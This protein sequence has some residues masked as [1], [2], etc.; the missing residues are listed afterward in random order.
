MASSQAAKEEKKRIEHKLE[1]LEKCLDKG[2][3]ETEIQIL[4]TDLGSNILLLD[5]NILEKL[6]PVNENVNLF[7]CFEQTVFFPFTF[8]S[9]TTS[10]MDAYGYGGSG[11][12]FS[13]GGGGG[14]GFGGFGGGGF[15]GGG[16]SGGW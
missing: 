10:E 16:A 15:G 2:G 12:G 8:N 9:V 4:T 1:V 3:D 13:G 14:I 7:P 5:T 11:G 6:I